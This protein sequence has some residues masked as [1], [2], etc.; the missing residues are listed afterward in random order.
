MPLRRWV[1]TQFVP[2]SP[3]ALD[4]SDTLSDQLGRPRLPLAAGSPHPAPLDVDKV[5]PADVPDAVLGR[6]RGVCPWTLRWRGI[7]IPGG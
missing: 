5:A 3:P 1:R 6:V 2:T 4:A 7:V